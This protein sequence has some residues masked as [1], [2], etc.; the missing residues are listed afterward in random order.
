MV[1]KQCLLLKGGGLPLALA[2]APPCL[3]LPPLR[4]LRRRARNARLIRRLLRNGPKGASLFFWGYPIVKRR[5]MN[6]S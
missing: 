4:A 1:S 3:P 5:H 2:T 6:L